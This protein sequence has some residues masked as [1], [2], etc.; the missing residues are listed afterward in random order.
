MIF[1][2]SGYLCVLYFVGYLF[3]GIFISQNKDVFDVYG[4]IMDMV[5]DKIYKLYDPRCSDPNRFQWFIQLISKYSVVYLFEFAIYMTL[6]SS[7][8]VYSSDKNIKNINVKSFLY[9][10]NFAVMFIFG[11]WIFMKYFDT[12]VP[13]DAKYDILNINDKIKLDIKKKERV[14]GERPNVMKE[15]FEKA[16][17]EKEQYDKE[18]PAAFSKE[19][20][21]TAEIEREAAAYKEEERKAG[22]DEFLQDRKTVREAE[23]KDDKKWVNNLFGRNVFIPVKI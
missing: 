4:D 23:K 17:A 3:F 21:E 6:I 7:M 20:N 11:I 22:V 18:N 1:P 5:F 8:I 15:S 2:F 14:E 12:I 10:I 9:I 16:R 19:T 13:L